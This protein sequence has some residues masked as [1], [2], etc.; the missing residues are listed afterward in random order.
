MTQAVFTAAGYGR[1][2]EVAPPVIK[3]GP[4]RSP[5]AA[6]ESRSRLKT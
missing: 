3:H 5:A 1:R 2:T 4:V 6:T